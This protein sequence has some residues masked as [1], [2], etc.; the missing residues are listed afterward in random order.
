MADVEGVVG[1]QAQGRD[2]KVDTVA[3][4][5]TSNGLGWVNRGPVRVVSV[6]PLPPPQPGTCFLENRVPSPEGFKPQSPLLL[7]L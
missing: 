4:E 5:G 6:P 3:E 1:T 7:G 2:L